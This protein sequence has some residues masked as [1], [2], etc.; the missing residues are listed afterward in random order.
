MR[1]NELLVADVG[2][3]DSKFIPSS[4]PHICRSLSCLWS[5]LL[6]RRTTGVR[7]VTMFSA[8]RGAFRHRNERH[9]VVFR[10]SASLTALLN[11]T[12]DPLI[13]VQ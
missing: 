6:S 2:S 9:R 1:R 11:D 8:V 10:A 5:W 12:T 13:Q 4:I 7:L 3:R